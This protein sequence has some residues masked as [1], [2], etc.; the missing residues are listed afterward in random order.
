V[1]LDLI[2]CFPFNSLRRLPRATLLP[3]GRVRPEPSRCN[4]STSA[5]VS[6]R[7]RRSRAPLQRPR[8]VARAAAPSYGV[9]L[10]PCRST[11]SCQYYA[12][13]PPRS[14][15]FAPSLAAASLWRCTRRSSAPPKLPA[16]ACPRAS[17]HLCT[18]SAWGRSRLH[19][20][21]RARRQRHARAILIPLTAVRHLGH[22]LLP[23]SRTCLRA[24]A[25][26]RC[27][28][29]PRAPRPRVLRRCRPLTEPHAPARPLAAGQA[30]R[31]SARPTR[32]PS[33]PR[34][35]QY[36]PHLAWGRARRSG[37]LPAPRAWPSAGCSPPPAAARARLSRCLPSAWAHCPLQPPSARA[38][39]Q[40]S[41]ALP[42]WASLHPSPGAR[43]GP[44]VRRW[45]VGEEAPGRPCAC[46]RG[47]ERG[48][49]E[50][51]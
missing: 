6:A 8:R 20:P 9:S 51:R 7:C 39:N 12:A 4:I 1:S 10:Y 33:A 19:Q 23:S 34:T 37:R 50:W 28:P 45:P 16:P 25:C 32:E 38:W 5:H 24:P 30:A 27:V 3:P 40:P 15:A 47:G 49:L 41:P 14:R 36:A 21:S 43:S 26:T 13:P 29:A 11:P 35:C 17:P 18:S 44:A 22:L 31:R 42:A 48:E 46:A 2:R